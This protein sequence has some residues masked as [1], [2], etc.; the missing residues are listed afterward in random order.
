VL[1]DLPKKGVIQLP[2]PKRPEDVRRT[3]NP[4]YCHYHR[5][6]SYRLQKC[7]TL[8][9]HI[10]HLIE[11]SIKQ[12]DYL[13]FNLEVWSPLFCTNLGGLAM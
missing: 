9:E 12:R 11:K 4:K 2:E 8:K 1:D 6:V 13:S 7:G 5:M 3:A 10:M